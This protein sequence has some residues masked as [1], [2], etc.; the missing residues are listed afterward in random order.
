M[1]D[2]LS[3]GACKT[4]T[5]PDPHMLSGSE[6][7]APSSA[8]S[9]IAGNRCKST[10]AIATLPDTR[11][12]CNSDNSIGN[13]GAILAAVDM[14]H[15]QPL[16]RSPNGPGNH[17]TFHTAHCNL[18]DY[19]C[20]VAHCVKQWCKHQRHSVQAL[21]TALR[22]RALTRWLLRTSSRHWA[23][24]PGVPSDNGIGSLR[25]LFSHTY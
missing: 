1:T 3:A 25:A 6:K 9:N 17:C 7:D 18:P 19:R 14:V 15:F 4:C 20:V 5:L 10:T 22:T 11:T 2:D 21:A 12:V 16:A 8:P 23:L 24:P 13:N